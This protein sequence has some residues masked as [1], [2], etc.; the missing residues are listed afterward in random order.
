[1]VS[2]FAPNPCILGRMKMM[3]DAL[4]RAVM[5]CV[6]PRVIWLS[7]L[8]L[9]VMVVVSMVVGYFFWESAVSATTAWV[10]SRE[11]LQSLQSWVGLG[12]T[13][14]VNMGIAKLLLLVVSIPMT[15]MICLL[16]VA[17]FMTPA[18]VDLVGERRF[19]TL[20]R[21]RGGS[22]LVSVLWSVGST[23]LAMLALVLS[24]PLWLIPPLIVVLPPLIWGW[25]T[26]RVFAFDALATHAS[27]EER[28]YIL[29]KY[30]GT[31]LLMGIMSGYLGAAPSLLWASGV[32]AF[33]LAFI[34]V[35]LAIWIYTL[36]FALASLW[37]SHFC[38]D[39]LQRRREET[40]AVLAVVD[41]TAGAEVES[42]P[43]AQP[44]T[45]AS[46]VSSGEAQR[47]TAKSQDIEDATVV[48]EASA[49][50]S[51]GSST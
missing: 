18:M 33:A 40:G 24:M 19:P 21:K 31:L 1:M 26:Y 47:T 41:P 28:K 3:L 10:A 7:L 5:Y 46:S 36:V 30:R 35:P 23:A 15:V 42:P 43:S 8:P 12:G 14:S 48:R 50:P 6:H 4:W 22:L 45:A 17:M 51:D 49:K 39:A 34:T 37:F 44:A 13:D 2:A 25:L 27:P 16:L 20:E 11:F 9:V 38:L 32:L 29:H